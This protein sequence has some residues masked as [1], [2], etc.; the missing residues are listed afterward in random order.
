MA[1]TPSLADPLVQAIKCLVATAQRG[2]QA[3]DVVPRAWHTA[4]W[5]VG[6]SSTSVFAQQLATDGGDGWDKILTGPSAHATVALR[7]R[8]EDGVVACLEQLLAFRDNLRDQQPALLATLDRLNGFHVTLQG[9]LG[10]P[11]HWTAGTTEAAAALAKTDLV[12]PR[13]G[14]VEATRRRWERLLRTSGRAHQHGPL[15]RYVAQ[16]LPV[17]APDAASAA[18]IAGALLGTTHQAIPT[19]QPLLEPDAVPHAKAV[20]ALLRAR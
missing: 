17:A 11:I 16:G 13:D 15:H 19:I 20:R 7:A 2:I 18:V 9:G 12:V 14:D 10:S 6:F 1:T 4:F 3:G 5:S 8:Y